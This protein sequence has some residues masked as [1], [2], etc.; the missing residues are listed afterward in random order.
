VPK[1]RGRP[2]QNK[3]GSGGSTGYVPTG[4]PRGRPKAN[5]APVEKHEDNDDDQDDENSGEEEHSSPEKTVVAPK[6]RGRPSL[7]AGKVSKEETTKPRSRPTKKNLQVRE[8]NT[9]MD[10]TYLD[11]REP[12][13]PKTTHF[14]YIYIPIYC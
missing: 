7:A 4:R 9:K 12:S 5:A 8:E 13:P 11:F 14:V 1:K 6:K 2:P 10:R 3:S